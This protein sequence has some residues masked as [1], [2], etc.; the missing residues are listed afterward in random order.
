MYV[1]P[2]AYQAHY[3]RISASKAAEGQAEE[4][5]V[6]QKQ[7]EMIEMEEARKERKQAEYEH[8]QYQKLLARHPAPPPPPPTASLA[9]NRR[10]NCNPDGPPLDEAEYQPSYVDPCDPQH[11]Y[12]TQHLSALVT[13]PATVKKISSGSG[14]IQIGYDQASPDAEAGC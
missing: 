9:Y 1:K 14:D 10:S 3:R 12:E 8:R 13:R 5:A 11:R 7:Q 2:E 4:Q 6:Y